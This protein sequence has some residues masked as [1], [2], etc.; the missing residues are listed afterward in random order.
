MRHCLG[1]IKDTLFKPEVDL[2]QRNDPNGI[3][4]SAIKGPGNLLEDAITGVVGR[5]RH[6]RVE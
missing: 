2:A 5:R 6:G 3:R 1:V 4:Q